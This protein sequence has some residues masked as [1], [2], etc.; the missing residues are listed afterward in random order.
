MSYEK[1]TW[2]TGDIVTAEKLNNIE[3]G[4]SSIDS[5]FPWKGKIVSIMGD[6]ISTFSGYIPIADGHN[7]NHRAFYP[8]SG[9]TDVTKTWWY[10]LI[11][12][13][14][15]KLGVN[16]SWSG[17]YV[18]N[19]TNSWWNYGAMGNINTSGVSTS[20]SGNDFGIKSCMAGLTRIENLASNGTPDLILVYGGTNDI[21][22]GSSRL[23]ILGDSYIVPGTFDSTK[24]PTSIDLTAV[25]WSS[26]A[27]AFEA[28]VTRLQYY[29][30]QSTIVV[31][32]PF[33]SDSNGAFSLK[34]LDAFIEVQRNI[35]DYYGINYIDLRAC[36]INMANISSTR[37]KKGITTI[38][39][40]N[41]H[42]NYLGFEMMKNYIKARV[43][44]IFSTDGKATITY[45]VTNLLT[46]NV[47]EDRYIK[48]VV[49]G[50]SYIATISG[51]T[52]T[53]IKISM[54]GTDITS[55]SYNS[56]T[57]KINISKVTGNIIITE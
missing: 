50:E 45:S 18:G 23:A 37:N 46:T 38:A 10:S 32:F 26:F 14:G 27:E 49:S 33:Y 22:S 53:K 29:Y 15:A 19:S 55:S 21:W 28:M 40:G 48:T 30:P 3:E 31:L 51:S 5:F 47:N 41:V 6:S 52:L 57:G 25:K 20:G 7:L 43:N 17:S 36:G 24:E 11:T 42:P 56:S 13:L 39:T 9:V 8:T 1:Q 12:E 16:D 2:K 35:C 4:I 44:S 54:N 34:K